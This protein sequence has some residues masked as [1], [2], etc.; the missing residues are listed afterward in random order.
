MLACI[1]TCYKSDMQGWCASR[2]RRN[3][4]EQCIAS[5]S[6]PA[7]PSYRM[8]PGCCLS[9]PAACLDGTSGCSQV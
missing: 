9:E 8:E 7:P 6:S 5:C 2:P 1:L 4:Q 3:L